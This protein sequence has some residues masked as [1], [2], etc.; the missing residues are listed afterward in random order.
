MSEGPVAPETSGKLPGG[1]TRATLR[2]RYGDRLRWMV[3]MTSPR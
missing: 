3:L 1:P 2:A